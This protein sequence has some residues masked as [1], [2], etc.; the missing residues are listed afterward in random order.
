VVV[1]WLGHSV[2][3]QAGIE[4][5]GSAAQSKIVLQCSMDLLEQ[6]WEVQIF[7]DCANV[8]AN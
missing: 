1:N 6:G 2:V 8:V 3:T 5:N 4:L 7:P